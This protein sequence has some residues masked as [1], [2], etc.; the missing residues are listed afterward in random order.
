LICA[1][2][3][4]PACVGTG[5]QAASRKLVARSLWLRQVVQEV[6]RTFPA[7]DRLG[8]PKVDVG[9]GM[10]GAE[11]NHGRNS[12][13]P[14]P[15]IHSRGR[16]GCIHRHSVLAA[17]SRPKPA[18][19]RRNWS[20]VGQTTCLRGNAGSPAMGASGMRCQRYAKL[21]QSFVE[22]P[23]KPDAS[24]LELLFHN[25]PFLVFVCVLPALV[26]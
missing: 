17:P 7:S 15:W 26:A 20:G 8:R 13:T 12:R 24:A 1:D 16:L 6:R 11:D 9:A 23:R 4:G 5:S 2:Y 22:D 21:T 14:T 18:R 25:G 3:I 10:Q 19:R